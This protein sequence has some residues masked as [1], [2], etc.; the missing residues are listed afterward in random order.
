LTMMAG[1]IAVD[2]VHNRLYFTY[3]S[4]ACG[5]VGVGDCAQNVVTSY[6][7]AGRH[8]TGPCYNPNNNRLYWNTWDDVVVYDCSTNAVRGPVANTS[9]YV[10]ATRLCSSLNKL[11]ACVSLP[12]GGNAIDVIDCDQDSVKKTVCLPDDSSGYFEALLLAPED[13]TLWFIGGNSVVAIDC[14]GDSII[15]VSLDAFGT[16]DDAIACPEDRR[17]YTG[18]S[19]STC[20][21]VNMD[22][23]ADIDTLHERIPEALEMH[24]VN[25]PG[26]HKAFWS[27]AYPSHWPGSSCIF[28]IDTKTNALVDSF[29]VGQ[30]I[31]DMCLDHT[32]DFSGRFSAVGD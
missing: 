11:Y 24:F 6:S 14:A 25:I 15:A 17:I 8:P 7:Y 2:T 19:S 13:N 10:Y 18:K 4:T 26:A 29:W 1:S 20:W 12:Q 27:Y 9:G 30:M 21:S 5:S 32:G 31:S 22:E 28:V 16:I 23:P 3:G